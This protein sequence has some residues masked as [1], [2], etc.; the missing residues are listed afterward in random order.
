M[1][2]LNKKI[3]KTRGGSKKKSQIGQDVD[4]IIS[5]KP[6]TKRPTGNRTHYEPLINP[7][8][9]IRIYTMAEN[10]LPVRDMAR[11]VGMG[12]KLFAKEIENNPELAQAIEDGKAAGNELI[13]RQLMKG[14]R[15]GNTAMVIFASKVRLNM[16]EVPRDDDKGLP[17]GK[18]PDKIEF[19][20]MTPTDAARVYQQLIKE[21]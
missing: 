5:P 7:F 15:E 13:S 21:G 17:D 6:K 12:E 19:N 2:K 8:D 11:L 10:A 4:G 3:T 1:P 14:V 18:K 9:M 20:K 16:R